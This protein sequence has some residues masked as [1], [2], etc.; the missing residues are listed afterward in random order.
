MK[1]LKLFTIF[2][3]FLFAVASFGDHGGDANFL[4]TDYASIAATATYTK[5]TWTRDELLV[6]PSSWAMVTVTFT[7]AGGDGNEI[8]FYFQVS[9]DNGATWSTTYWTVI[10]VASDEDGVDGVVRYQWLDIYPGVSHIRLWKI[11]NGDQITAI[12][13]V[14]ASLSWGR[15]R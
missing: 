6:I 7:T 5:A 13:D 1:R 15:V 4:A 8:E 3:V 9:C 14:N 11:Y 2:L 12:T 10:D